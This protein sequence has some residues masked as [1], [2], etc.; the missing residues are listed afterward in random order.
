MILSMMGAGS[1]ISQQAPGVTGRPAAMAAN[2]GPSDGKKLFTG[3]VPLQ[4]GGPPCM[5]CHNIAGLP[6]PRGGSV[7]PDLTGVAAKFG[8]GL[9]ATL[10]TLPFP[11]MIPIFG[12]RPLTDTERRD[13]QSFLETAT[14]P[15]ASNSASTIALS[16]IGGFILLLVLT[17]G[18]WKHRLTTV[19]KRLLKSG[20]VNS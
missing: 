4:N 2:A 1:L 5:A 14:G 3:I 11:T 16:E 15:S 12:K 19:R 13:L 10:T 20:G 9:N 8:A 6:F 17:W 18:V 7:G